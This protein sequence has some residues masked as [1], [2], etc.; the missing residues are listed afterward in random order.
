MEHDPMKRAE[1]MEH[2]REHLEQLLGGPGT[3]LPGPPAWRPPA[4]A[5][6]TETEFVIRMD[7]AGVA[8]EDLAVT[9]DRRVL[10]IHGVRRD[11]MPPGRK[12]FHKMEIRVGPFERRFPMPHD[13]GGHAVRATY[14]DGI[15]EVHVPKE[16]GGEIHEIEITLG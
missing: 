12:T 7:I 1:E 14:Q 15:L 6:E 4:D 13:C 11:A 3:H 9:C 16:S 8:R 10:R 5:Y 2:L